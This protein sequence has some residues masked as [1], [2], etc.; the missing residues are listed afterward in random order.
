MTS[1]YFSHANG[2]PS[3]TYS[4]LFKFLKDYNIT[5]IDV[6]GAQKKTNEVDWINLSKEIIDGVLELNKPVI[7][8]GHSLGGILTLLAASNNP[9][10]F[11][12][13][14]LLDPPI[15]SPLKRSIIDFLRLIQI[16]DLFSP[17][18]KSKK[19]RE[20]FDSKEQALKYF[21]IK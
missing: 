19:R 6:I 14:I 10:I 18:R 5:T 4:V 2:F 11:K 20:L 12:S 8:I 17:A 21:K 3:K 7:G 13:V 1:I 9:K 16:E 15:F